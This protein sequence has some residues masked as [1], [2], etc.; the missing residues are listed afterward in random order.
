M[1]GQEIM[2]RFSGTSPDAEL[3]S[4]IKAGQVGGV[5]LFGDNIVS[6]AQAKAVVSALQAAAQ[7]GSNPPLLISTDQEGGQVKRL[8]WAAPHMSAQAMGA[9]P[10]AVAERAGEQTGA[11]LRAVG[12]N[13]DLAPV[14][15]VAHSTSSFIWRQSRSFGLSAGT[16]TNAALSF[17]LG[18]Q[19][20]NVAPTAKHFPGLGGADTTTDTA[21]QTLDS[22]TEDRA[23]YAALIG[24]HIPLIMV[25]TARFANLDPSGTPAA[26]SRP[27]VTGLLRGTMGYQGVVI[28]DDLQAP[29]NYSTADAAVRAVGAG[30]D[31]VLAGATEGG[32]AAAYAA[33]R[34]AAA[35]GRIPLSNIE[36]ADQR[37]KLLKQ[38]YAQGG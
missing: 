20:Q 9:G 4:R 1:V 30:V 11:D 25:S 32:G 17:S 23:P 13:V 16:V 22:L 10:G 38:R 21:Q 36:A 26:L 5:I 34:S 31:I 28:T 14:V 37:I 29:T 12:V 24:N 27:I 3:L 35:A 18:M 6:P 19:S 7:A 2:A 33:I 8:P 15:D